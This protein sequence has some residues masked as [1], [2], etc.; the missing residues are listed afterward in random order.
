MA[1]DWNAFSFAGPQ[2]AAIPSPQSQWDKFTFTGPSSED[3]ANRTF[4]PEEQTMIAAANQPEFG[5]GTRKRMAE[6][7]G[8]S[9]EQ[10]SAKYIAGQKEAIRNAYNTVTDPRKLASAAGGA[11]KAVA[12]AVAHPI[13]TAQKIGNY[14]YENPDSAVTDAAFAAFPARKA[15]GL[16]GGGDAIRTSRAMPRASVRDESEL[17]S[18]GGARM[19]EAKKSEA[20]VPLSDVQAPMQRFRERLSEEALEIDP[21]YTNK[22]LG[23]VI[24]RLDTAYTP[25]KADP[26]SPLTKTAPAAKPPMSLKEL[27]AHQRRLDDVISESKSPDGRISTDGVIAVELKKSVGEMIDAHPESSSFKIGKHEYHRGKMSQSM[28][29]IR[30]GAESRSTWGN[31]D[32]AGALQ[33]EIKQFLKN[34]KNRYAL[35]PEVRRK[36]HVLSQDNKGKLIG[37]FSMKNSFGGNVFARGIE[38]AVGFPGALAG[39]G[40]LARQDRNARIVKEFQNLMEEIRAGGPVR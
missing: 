39:P 26:M 6:Y 22:K 16:L 2:Q 13:D 10:A 27:H 31:G 15:M 32:E 36:L 34:K 24:K 37:S 18:T 5:A 19:K 38:T 23:N 3:E 30:K 1:T 11:I 14:Y 20:T 9:P 40:Y 21:E 29:D 4:T 17:L 25:P 8:L 33:A 35:T 12:G 28:G 7:E